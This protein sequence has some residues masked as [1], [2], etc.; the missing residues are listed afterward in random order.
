MIKIS[1]L[2]KRLPELTAADFSARWQSGYGE[3]LQALAV[4][5]TGV[6]RYAQSHAVAHES[7]IANAPDSAF[8]GVD[9]LWCDS[10]DSAAALFDSERYREELAPAERDFVDRASSAVVVGKV[11]LMWDRPKQARAD[12]VKLLILP[13]RKPGL[14]VTEFRH[15]WIHVHSPLSLQGPGMRERVQRIEFCPGLR[16]GIAGLSAADAEGTGS[17]W[18]DSMQQLHEEFSSPYYRDTLQPDEKRFSDGQ[19]SRG[20]MTHERRVWQRSG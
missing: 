6:V 5:S 17:I 1:R 9:E 7:P 3:A 14:T 2:F 16:L 18:F 12:A 15:H 10:I 19:R 20:S 4:Q 8:D 11:L 13:A